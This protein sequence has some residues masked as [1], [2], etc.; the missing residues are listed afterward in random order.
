MG[1][2][3]PLRVVS[4]ALTEEERRVL[5]EIAETREVSVSLILRESLA[6]TLSEFA[7]AASERVGHG[8][9]PRGPIRAT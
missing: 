9:R 1:V 4:V 3:K 8:G 5:W 6:E 7:A 2:S